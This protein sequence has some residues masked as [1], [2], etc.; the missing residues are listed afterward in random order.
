METAGPT[1]ADKKEIVMD[2]RAAI[3]SLLDKAYAARRTQ[4]VQGACALFTDDG[5]FL[6]NGAPAATNSRTEQ[7]AALKGMFDAFAVVEFQE[8][9]RIIDP[10][11]AVVHWRGT[12]RAKNGQLGDTD[13]LDLFEVRDGRIA[14]LTSF[15]DTAYA[16]ALAG[17]PAAG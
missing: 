8:H 7:A 15:F 5:R 1:A 12:F 9:C 11:R 14:A 16:A 2:T 6:A 3:D 13:V 4:D 10:P 17:G